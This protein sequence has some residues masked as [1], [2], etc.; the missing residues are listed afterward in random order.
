MN[1]YEVLG[2][3]ENATKDE[4]KSAYRKLVKQYHPDQY[5][6]NPLKDLA[7]EKLTEINKAYEML[8]SNTSSSYNSN[9]NS[10]TYS[11]SSSDYAVIRRY[12]NAR[13]LT[14]AER[15]L[16]NISSKDAEWY[17]LSGAVAQAKGWFDQARQYY[18]TACNMDPNN[19]EYRKAYNNLVQRTTTYSGPYRQ[20]GNNS[21]NACDCCCDLICLDSC[22]ECMGGDLIP[23]I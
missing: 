21:S 18:S 7:A 17:F 15:M 16:N 11:S 14:S 6:N 9:N 5:A 20:Y 23:C 4:I 13:D 2:V 3:S 1:P 22:C 12:I 8:M 10:S 19:F